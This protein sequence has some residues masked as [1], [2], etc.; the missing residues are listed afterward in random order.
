[1]WSLDRAGL[2]AS[3]SGKDVGH[4][5]G[6][7]PRSCFHREYGMPAAGWVCSLLRAP[8]TAA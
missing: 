8:P 5:E 3:S 6:K 7:M 2:R 1:M 4:K